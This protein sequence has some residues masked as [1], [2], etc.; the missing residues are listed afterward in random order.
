MM[1]RMAVPKLVLME[2]GYNTVWNNAFWNNASTTIEQG[3]NWSIFASPLT[4]LLISQG[5]NFY[6]GLAKL[7]A[8]WKRKPSSVQSPEVCPRVTQLAV[9]AHSPKVHLRK[10]LWKLFSILLLLAWSRPERVRRI[11]GW[12]GG[13]DILVL[14]SWIRC[15]L[16]QLW[17]GTAA[18]WSCAPEQ[19]QNQN[20]APP[21]PTH[22]RRSPH[23][24][25]VPPL[26]A[27]KYR[28]KVLF[29]KFWSVSA[30]TDSKKEDQ[31]E[32]SSAIHYLT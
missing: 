12:Q 3:N 7:Q 21:T 23:R 20:Q 18:G 1:N 31:S 8:E 15:S 16:T 2:H 14:P 24:K 6:T 5:Q 22:N 29:K 10:I 4:F 28:G 19:N 9:Q 32:S 30:E 25:P 13:E 17:G 26:S 27:G 11:Q